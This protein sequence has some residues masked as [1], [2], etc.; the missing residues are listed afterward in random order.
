M[1]YTLPTL[2]PQLRGRGALLNPQ[3]PFSSEVRDKTPWLW[4]AEG[5]EVK[6][7]TK[8]VD[9]YPKTIVNK[10][11]SPDV[12]MEY[13]LNPYQGC[14]HGCVYCYARNT[15][16]Y[17]GYSSGVDFESVILIKRNASELLEK[18]LKSKTW[19]GH[20]IMLS[21]NT[22]CYQ[23]IEK[24]LE[25]TREL[26]QIFLKYK[27]P[28]GI[29]TKNALILRDLD[30]LKEL[31]KHQLISVAISINTLDDDL[32][33]IM[34]PR[35][36]SVQKRLDTVKI[37]AKEKIPV[38]V[39]AA[40]IIPGLNDTDILPLAKKVSEAGAKRLSHIVVRLNG[41][42]AEIFTHWLENTFPDRKEKVLNK[43]RSLFGGKLGSSQFVDRMKGAGKI[44]DIIH[45]QFSM[46]KKL[47]MLK[48]E[49][50][51]YNLNSYKAKN[52][53]QL[54]LFS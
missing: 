20:P 33:R 25:I 10:V 48:D 34:E 36:S 13:S 39:L 8:L 28:V 2:Q 41:D 43:I 18:L 26:L 19:T 14:E 22:D 52:G 42:I 54:E 21:G 27:H 30:I 45:Q 46:A 9:T 24:E 1:Y 16:P 44:A 7:K 51:E 15:H 3:N 49:H 32:R 11:D 5:D 31:N 29:V 38:T 37:L 53:V 23:P 50:F 17:W 12:G 47:Y 4:D 35:T 40:P 6:I